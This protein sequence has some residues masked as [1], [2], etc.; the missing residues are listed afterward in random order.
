MELYLPHA[1][2]KKRPPRPRIIWTDEMITI[3][4]EQFPLT[5]NKELAAQLGVSWRSLIRKAR[6]LGIEKEPGF[7]DKNRETITRMGVEKNYNKYTGCKGWSVPNSEATR[8]K[9]GNISAMVT[10]PDVVQKVRK[11]RNE[12]IR[13][14]R[15]RIRLGL[16]RLTNLNLK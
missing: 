7:L 12:T 4:R 14:E 11:T 9:P 15:I 5:F 10:N 2:E 6:E 13:R 8:F 16:T 3:V 1:P